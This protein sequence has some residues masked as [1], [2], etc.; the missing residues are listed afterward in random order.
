LKRTA[1]DKINIKVKELIK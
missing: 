1:L